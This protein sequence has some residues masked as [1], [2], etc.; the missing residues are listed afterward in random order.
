MRLRSVAS[1]LFAFGCLVLAACATDD[2]GSLVGWSAP[3]AGAHGSDDAGAAADG[4]SSAPPSPTGTSTTPPPS[5]DAGANPP[6]GVDASTPPGSDAGG[7]PPPAQDASVPPANGFDQFQNH[8]LDVINMYRATLNVA[9]LV[10][11]KQLCDF[12]L[13]GSQELSQDHMPHQHF[14]TASNNGTLWT[15]G[16]TSNA[17]ENQGDP[18]GWTVLSNNPTQNELMQIDSIQKAMFDE[19]PGAGEAHGHYTNMMNPALHRLGVG[20]LEVQNQL[21]LTND[22]SD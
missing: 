17:A 6:P 10:L 11:D 13:A 16:F 15:S 20:L 4:S 9:P 1:G 22:F 2:P 7:N 8:N 5:N 3:P 19:G 12:A 18:N 21:Y 14:I